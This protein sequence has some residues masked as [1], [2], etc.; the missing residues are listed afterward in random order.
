MQ[1]RVFKQVLSNGLTVLAVPRRHIPKVS[2]Q[3]FY[4]VGSKDEHSGEKGIAHLIE[5]MI[6]KG[7]QKLSES[8]INLIT[9]K[10]SGYCNAFTSYDY[11]G[12][13]F[14]FPTQHWAESLPIMSDCME[15]C[16]FKEQLLNSEL[17][18]VIQELKMYNDDYMRTLAELLITIIFDSHPYH[19]PIIGYKQDL[20]SVRRER[21][22]AFYKKH[23][24][25][26]N[27][28]LIG[29]GDINPD[30]FFAQ[31]ETYF[32]FLKPDPNY[33][34]EEF[35][36]SP[37]LEARSVTLYRDIQQPFTILA[38]VVPG[39]RQKK[40]YIAEQV[41][42]ILGS[43]KGSR[44]YKKLVYELGLVTEIETFSY[45]L[46]DHGV[47]FLYFQPK[48][49]ASTSL[50]IDAIYGELVDLAAHGPQE[51]E[52]TRAAKKIESEF[53]TIL[54]KNQRLAYA[55]GE[56]YL[57]TG[58]EHYF[59]NYIKA[60]V[61]A[62]AVQEYIRHYLRPAVTHMGTVL[63]IDESEKLFWVERQQISDAEDARVLNHIT[64]ELAVEEGVQVKTV[65]TRLPEKFVFPKAT[66][67]SLENGLKAFYY[68][69]PEVPKIELVL[70]L[71]AKYYYDP[72]DLQ[73]IGTFVGDLLLEGTQEYSGAELADIFESLGMT[74]QVGAGTITMSVL[75]EDLAKGLRLLAD[76]L[77]HATLSPESVEKVRHELQADV[78]N[79]WDTPTQFS[80]QLARQAVYR[81]HP[82]HKNMLGSQ[83]SLR[84]IT[85]E[86]LV[87]Y[88]QT[89]L[90][91]Q[92]A[93][94]AI[95]GDLKDYDMQH[96]LAD[97]LGSWTGPKVQSIEF[98]T[99]AP[100]SSGEINYPINRDQVVLCF[101]GLSV[102]R[103]DPL[104]EKINLFDQIFTGGVLGTMSSR[105]FALR[106][107]SGLFYT[108]GGS[109][110]FGAD[111]RPGMTFIKTIVSHDRLH[112]AENAITDTINQA[113]EIMTDEEFTAARDALINSLVDNFATNRSIANAFL[114]LD[115]FGFPADYF[116]NRAL[117]L[118]K[119][120][121][122]EACDA[123]A[124]VLNTEQMVKIRIGRI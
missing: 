72:E 69:N 9:Q 17:K 98:P 116:D 18:A 60:P 24:V 12:Y 61:T 55:I 75:A 87:S 102:S 63:P 34:K 118:S 84:R 74:V 66:S 35:Y 48:D 56:S 104:Y 101:A 22:L 93:R 62:V 108:I 70:D 110:T 88:Y 26:N 39:A 36:W 81:K 109:L 78:K 113:T 5:H 38:W 73:G 32:G 106:E 105:L 25:P 3:L 115:R 42:W 79:F 30:D 10:L 14:D 122:Q 97:T 27:A 92:D 40:D 100:V 43:G 82:Y 49:Q 41:S 103:K 107:R 47:L 71:K 64:R 11:T 45:N 80:V 20:W 85:R 111:E 29:V 83:E 16:V 68:H 15:N 114:F 123:A 96:L 121:P 33:K 124:T 31:A 1:T 54:E 120:T 76:M 50:I 58:D 67:F 44:L 13:L 57:A 91:P 46:F 95:V 2:T 99:L 7:T 86:D 65:V 89:M 6:F 19:H 23:Y 59:L 37:D 90:S 28:T 8:D 4:N 53:L 94:L 112:E 117:M 21:L 52:L 119:I 77:M 51:H